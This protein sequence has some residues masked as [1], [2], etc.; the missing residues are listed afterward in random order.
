MG[1]LTIYGRRPPESEPTIRNLI[2]T[3]ALGIGELLELHAFFESCFNGQHMSP[4][5]VWEHTEDKTYLKPVPRK[6]PPMMGRR[7]P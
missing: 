7:S 6:D 2:E 5:G 3:G 4:V 1:E